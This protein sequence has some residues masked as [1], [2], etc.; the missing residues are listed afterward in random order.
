VLLLLK[1]H[2][3]PSTTTNN[4]E[5][6]GPRTPTISKN[7]F[8][9]SQ[10]PREEEASF[11]T[12]NP[13]EDT[14]I[15][16][17]TAASSSAASVATARIDEEENAAQE[18]H[19]P[20]DAVNMLK[21]PEVSISNDHA[22]NEHDD[23]SSS[24]NN[25][26]DKT[27]QSLPLQNNTNATK[28]N[29]NL[30][31][32]KPASNSN[33]NKSKA[34]RRKRGRY[35]RVASVD[36]NNDMNKNTFPPLPGN[37]YRTTLRRR[38]IRKSDESTAATA[39]SSTTSEEHSQEYMSQ[40]YG[41]ISLG[42]KLIVVGGRVIVQ[43]LNALADGRA[44]P[45]QLAGVI[46]RGD[47]LLSIEHLSLVNLPIDQ[48]MEG[49]KPLSAPIS[50]NGSY[51][52]ILQLRFEA[53]AGL[54]L[55]KNHEETEA[56]KTSS[57]RKENIDA[58][59]DMFSLFPMVDQL[60]GTP[61][62]EDHHNTY[63]P[64]SKEKQQSESTFIETNDAKLSLATTNDDDDESQYPADKK[65]VNEK[66]QTPDA[67]ISAALARERMMDREKFTSEFF[68]WNDDLSEWLRTAVRL[69]YTHCD[70]TDGIGMTRKERIE[71]GEK[72]M[73]VVKMM[74]YNME[75]VDKGKDMRSFRRWNSTLSLRSK[76]SVRRRFVLD[77]ASLLGNRLDRF[78]ESDAADSDGESVGSVDSTSL[79]GED[80]DELLLRLAAHDDI[81]RKQ[82]LETLKKAIEAMEDDSD[83]PEE[84]DEKK[85][86]ALDSAITM[87]L[88][89]FLFGENMTR[90]I[91]KRKRTFALPPE[92]IT[93]VL[94]DLITN[95]ASSAPDE[96][97]VSGH[98]STNRSL[99]SGLARFVS[100][101]PVLPGTDVLLATRFVLDE[102][103]PIWLKSFHPLPW[104]QR[105]VLWPRIK[106]ASAD[107]HG[108]TS[109][110]FSDDSLTVDSA[111]SIRSSSVKGKNLREMIEDQELDVET[112]AET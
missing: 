40:E 104:D 60:S 57:E 34:K 38:A 63:S 6:D 69:V 99:Q 65:L 37:Q 83:E 55:L 42:M 94:F 90:I 92:E 19:N 87:E 82:V 9:T 44:S 96:I 23:N 46:Q 71:A 75:D 33:N 51:Q 68:I 64:R 111:A 80:G 24:S 66:R 76:A 74:S 50:A 70:N 100:A 17:N 110:I 41:D 15:S 52:R 59:N 18:M 2:M 72:V 11:I 4:A 89:T 85:E 58:A 97:T 102:A 79:E 56:W 13:S 43:T 3:T 53:K 109:T 48:L 91:T 93:S 25:N 106:H 22:K 29:K 26:D 31:T 8:T 14:L 32:Q 86:V 49:L 101:K 35:V 107:S 27:P 81:W 105:R 39:S 1:K 16:S 28:A 7:T 67:L 84:K 12:T 62:F 54:E 108:G 112:R 21:I 95:I 88:G 77:A 103:I 98:T 47:A 10:A 78:G 30:P 5:E 36:E 61:L 73:Q 20:Q 45:A